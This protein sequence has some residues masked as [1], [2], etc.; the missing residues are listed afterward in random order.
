MLIRSFV[1]LFVACV[2]VA[3]R[4]HEVELQRVPVQREPERLP[5]GER[6]RQDEAAGRPAEPERAARRRWFDDPGAGPSHAPPA[7]VGVDFDDIHHRLEMVL[8]DVP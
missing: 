6:R 1:F 8:Q 3:P 2:D 4:E 7:A 5:C